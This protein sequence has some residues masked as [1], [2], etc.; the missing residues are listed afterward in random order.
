MLVRC[1][2]R[3]A[4]LALMRNAAGS[5]V[6]LRTSSP[7]NILVTEPRARWRLLDFGIATLME[8]RAH[9]IVT[10]LT[11]PKAAGR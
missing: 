10:Q 9:A 11:Q 7:S 5:M 1:Q 6:H 4:R 2:C 8:R 3:S